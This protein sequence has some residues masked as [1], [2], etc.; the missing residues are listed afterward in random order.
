MGPD[1]VLIRVKACGICGSDI[2]GMDGGT[3][4]RIPPIVM[5]HEAAGEIA[6][7]GNAVTGWSVGDRVTFDSTIFCSQCDFCQS[8]QVNLCDHRQVLGVSCADYRRA[9]AFAEYVS[10]PSRILYAIPPE[11]SFEQAAMVEPVSV[12]LHAVNRAGVK[13]GDRVAVIGV[14][15]IGLIVVQV[16]KARK[17]SEIIAVDLDPGKLE[18]AAKF[19]ADQTVDTCAGMDLD[20]A[21]EAVGLTSTV[22]M[23][24]ESVRKGGRVSLIGNLSPNV[25]IPLQ[26]VVTRELTLLGSCASQNDY[27]ESLRLIADGSVNVD[28]LISEQVPLDDAAS[29]FARLHDKEPGLMKVMVRP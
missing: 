26:A 27:A 10:V 4:R 11:L 29:A 23:A 28:A 15:M 1:E 3:G 5:G 14:G 24:I 20:V 9:G 13:L 21:L 22:T 19:G 17:A 7:I 16:L 12:A 2:H 8:G 25:Q 18:M 6:A